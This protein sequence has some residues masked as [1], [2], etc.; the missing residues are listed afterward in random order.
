MIYSRDR[1]IFESNE[2]F[3]C[4]KESPKFFNQ[5]AQFLNKKIKIYFYNNKVLNTKLKNIDFIN[6]CIEIDD[7]SE[8]KIALSDW[9]KIEG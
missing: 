2:G 1:Y 9:L 4:I 7:N 8:K 3:T 6:K 5:L